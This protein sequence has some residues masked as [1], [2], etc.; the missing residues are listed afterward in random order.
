M[1]PQIQVNHIAHTDIDNTQESLVS[2]LKFLLVKDLNSNNGGVFDGTAANRLS[3]TSEDRKRVST[4]VEALVPVRIER[5]L[6]Y[7]SGMCLL[8]IHRNHS[9]RVWKTEHFA[10]RKTI[11]SDDYIPS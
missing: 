7:A 9:E 2:P 6:Y 10:L 4:H 3:G 1:S 5:F 8:R 11:S